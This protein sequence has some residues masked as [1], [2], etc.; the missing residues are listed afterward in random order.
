MVLLAYLA[1]PGGNTA[2]YFYRVNYCQ[3]P[4]SY[5]FPEFEIRVVQQLHYSLLKMNVNRLIDVLINQSV[6]GKLLQ[7]HSNGECR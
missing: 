5:T 6:R 7:N 1:R 4:I 3:Q 2:G